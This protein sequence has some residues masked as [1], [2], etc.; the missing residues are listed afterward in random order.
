MIGLP[1]KHCKNPKG[2]SKTLRHAKSIFTASIMAVMISACVP[3]TETNDPNL[4]SSWVRPEDPQE[5]IGAKE[6]PAV[7]STYGGVYKD[8]KAE[9]LIAVIV[10]K[11]VAVSA[12]PT[13]VYKITLLNTPKVNAFALPGG[14]LYVTRGILALANDSSELAAVLAHEMAHVTADHAIIRQEKLSSNK[15]AEEVV[16]DVLDDN[17]AG[18]IALAAN[19]IRLSRFSQNQELQADT[20]G[21]RMIGRAGYDPYAASRFLET[22]EGYRKFLAGN[23][24]T[25]DS[26]SIASNH[27]STPRRVEYAIRHARN[28]GSPGFGDRAQDR[29]FQGIDGLLFGDTTDEGFVRGREFSHKSLGIRFTAPEGFQ[30]SNTPKA[31]MISG[32]DE[33]L[34]QF[35]AT[36]LSKRSKLTD[37]MKSGWVK[38]LVDGTIKEA[39]VNGLEGATAIASGEGFRF[40]IQLLRKNTQVYRFVT[41]APQT[42]TNLD[43]VS[44]M[45][46][47]SFKLLSKREIAKLKPLVVRIVE[48]KKNDTVAKISKKMKGTN[49]PEA[50]FRMINGLQA[51]SEILPGNKVKIVTE[52]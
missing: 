18:R 11:L 15:I 4:T 29:Y 20:I 10:S 41:A 50:L 25:F 3:Q 39:R 36:V 24:T 44:D 16:S 30:I 8:E 37:Y 42:N 40:K 49:N 43:A 13:R 52:S 1:E 17:S 48:V 23:R 34:T 19:R 5:Q 47:D 6:H 22:M 38:G 32:P 27:P 26:D 9:R 14:F 45:I 33:I 12:D 46:A 28:F 51:D 35:D 21:I 7:L 31:V 2:L